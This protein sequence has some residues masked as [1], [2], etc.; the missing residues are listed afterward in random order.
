M[1]A[2]QTAPGSADILSHIMEDYFVDGDGSMYMLD[3]IK[4][5]MM[6]DL[7]TGKV[8]MKGE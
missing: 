3:R 2:F 8:R 6:R 1:S 5:G 4:E 7:L